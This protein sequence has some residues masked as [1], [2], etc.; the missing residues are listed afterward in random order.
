MVE[1]N[2]VAKILQTKSTQL[3]R[4]RTAFTVLP[5]SA[6]LAKPACFCQWVKI[7]TCPYKTRIPPELAFPA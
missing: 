4:H 6:M 7:K 1:A 5:D 3:D 2:G